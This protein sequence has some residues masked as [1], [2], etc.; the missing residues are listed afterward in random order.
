VYSRNVDGK[1]YT[2]GVSGRLY[3]SN[4]LLYD[5]QTESLWSQLMKKAISGPLV[6]KELQ[7]L[8]AERMP[9]KIWLKDN[10]NTLLLSDNTGYQRDYSIDPYEGYYRIGSLMFP[11][12]DVRRDLPAKEPI[13]GVEIDH[14][15]KAYPM[16]WLRKNPGVHKDQVGNHSIRIEIGSQGDTITVKDVRG[17]P[18]PAI[19]AYWFAWQAFHQD[20]QVFGK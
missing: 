9:W 13:L 6:Q 20:T 1:E 3:K 11:V 2:F 5:H 12:G 19:Y 14:H 15:A 18:I 10:P 17:Q 4:V 16:D 7:M 8:I